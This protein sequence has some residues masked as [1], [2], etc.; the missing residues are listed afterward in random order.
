MK[1]LPLEA[2]LR[3]LIRMLGFIVL[4]TL[5]APLSDVWRVAGAQVTQS[6]SPLSAMPVREFTVFV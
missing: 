6:P 1:T 2:P 5:L 3:G 4:P